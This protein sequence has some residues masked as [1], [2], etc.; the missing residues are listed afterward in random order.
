M[1][2]NTT[3]PLEYGKVGDR[4]L[5]AVLYR[6][7]TATPHPLSAILWIHGGAWRAGTR[8]DNADLCQAIAAAGFVCLSIDYR[9]SQ[10]AIFPAAIQDCHCAVRYLRAHAAE[11]GI[12]PDRIGAWGPSAG[13][14]LAALLGV[15]AHVPEFTNSGGWPGVSSASARQIFC[16][17][18]PTPVIWIMTRLTRQ[19]R[20]SS[21][22]RSQ[23]TRIASGR[24]TPS[25]IYLPPRRPC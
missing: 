3:D 14:H 23:H 8:H 25:L 2:I 16:K 19:S 24:P 6:P 15:S 10:E 5:L 21:A 9:L 22:A 11:L 17:C 20:S 12:A 7:Q 18:L 13:G 4:P 1:N